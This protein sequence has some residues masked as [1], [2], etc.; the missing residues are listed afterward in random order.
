MPGLRP[1]AG[2]TLRIDTGLFA[3]VSAARAAGPAPAGATSIL[4][5][6]WANFRSAPLGRAILRA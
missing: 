6:L 3:R 5:E 4:R 1:G 2:P